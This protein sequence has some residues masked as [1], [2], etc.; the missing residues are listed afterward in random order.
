MDPLTGE[1]MVKMKKV[2]NK[3]CGRKSKKD[4]ERFVGD[5]VAFPISNCI[6]RNHSSENAFL[7]ASSPTYNRMPTMMD[8][9]TAEERDVISMLCQFK[10]DQ[11]SNRA[12]AEAAASSVW[13]IFLF[14]K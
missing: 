10:S 12:K 6:A 11:D 2:Q 7:N 13:D 8:V 1:L 4:V 14:I 3:G 5:S 9:E